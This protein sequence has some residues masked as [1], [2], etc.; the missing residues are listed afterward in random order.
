MH[1]VFD[2]HS[3]S[4]KSQEHVFAIA[5]K[6]ENVEL[7]DDFAVDRESPRLNLKSSTAAQSF[8]PEYFFR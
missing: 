7:A 5:D 8:I 3:N 6:P 4:P 1:D 2:L